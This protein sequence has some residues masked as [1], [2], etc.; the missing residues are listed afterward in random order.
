VA[1]IVQ[2]L[3]TASL[4]VRL[5][6]P[7]FLIGGIVMHLLGVA[8]A[9]A[10]GV[11]LSIPALILGQVVVTS[12]QLM[13]HYA[14]DY[15][16]LRADRANATPT[17]WS[18]GS[19]ILPAGLLRPH[20]ALRTALVLAAVALCTAVALALFVQPATL[21]LP[22]ILLSMF[23]AWA[24]SAPPFNLH[25]RGLGQITGTIVVALLTPMVGF[26]LQAGHLAMLPVWASLPIAGL[27]FAMLTIVDFPDREG[28]MTAGKQTMVVR[29]G[30]PRAVRLY[31]L[32]IL[33]A[34]ALL[35]V[36]V[37]AGALPLPVALGVALTLPL[38]VW[39]ALQMLTS[40]RQRPE[41]WGELIFWTIACL[42]L[43][44]A[45]AVA[46]FLSLAAERSPLV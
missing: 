1:T 10:V 43:A 20:V 17:A 9:M 23:L 40:A 35:P 15:F 26:Y 8:A 5:G 11:P 28:D 44:G 34:Y 22:L 45:L 2:H 31:V 6:R 7:L 42:V 39:L 41:R 30:L 12:A 14:N 4:W 37:L 33:A 38:G 36:L 16:D 13:T 3:K 18:G 19:R 24:Y 46:G 21:A 29:L 32:S 25:G 27:Q